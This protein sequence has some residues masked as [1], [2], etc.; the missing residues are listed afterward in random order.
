MCAGSVL[1]SGSILGFAHKASAD[2]VAKALLDSTDPV[3]DA[4]GQCD[5]VEAVTIDIVKET[6]SADA[7][8][9]LASTVDGES[10]LRSSVDVQ[11]QIAILEA[12]VADQSDM[13][14]PVPTNAKTVFSSWDEVPPMPARDASGTAVDTHEISAIDEERS[15]QLASPEP[16]PVVNTASKSSPLVPEASASPHT[17]PRTSA[18]ELDD[19]W[20]RHKEVAAAKS[21]A[22]AEALEVAGLSNLE[23]DLDAETD[24]SESLPDTVDESGEMGVEKALVVEQQEQQE[25]GLRD[26]QGRLEEGEV[27][28]ESPSKSVKVLAKTSAV[29]AAE[30]A[31]K[32]RAAEQEA[33]SADRLAAKARTDAVKARA[34]ESAAAAKA[35]VAAAALSAVDAVK[36]AQNSAVR[37]ESPSPAEAHAEA[38][39]H[40]S[41]VAAAAPA[42]MTV[43]PN[44]M[45]T[46][47][48]DMSIDFDAESDEDEDEEVVLEAAV[49]IGAK[50]REAAQTVAAAKEASART[51]AEEA[52]ARLQA[53]KDAVE[54]A[55]AEMEETRAR[56]EAE[57]AEASLLSAKQREKAHAEIIAELEAEC[58][59]SED[60]EVGEK[61]KAQVAAPLP[62]SPCSVSGDGTGAAEDAA[63]HQ[64]PPEKATAGV[65]V[66][67][68]TP[69]SFYG[70][71]ADDEAESPHADYG[72]TH[73]PYGHELEG[74]S[75]GGS[76]HPSHTIATVDD[77]MSR[78][79]VSRR[80]T[81]TSYPPPTHH[82]VTTHSLAHPLTQP[83]TRIFTTFLQDPSDFVGWLR[84]P[85]SSTK[86]LN[87]GET[88]LAGVGGAHLDLTDFSISHSSPLSGREES[89][90]LTED[91]S[92]ASPTDFSTRSETSGRSG[93]SGFD[94]LMSKIMAGPSPTK[95][96]NS[97]RNGVSAA[98][99]AE[100]YTAVAPSVVEIGVVATGEAA[101]NQA[102]EAQPRAQPRART[103]NVVRN[104]DDSNN[105]SG[106]SDFPFDFSDM[107]ETPTPLGTAFVPDPFPVP[108]EQEDTMQGES[109]VKSEAAAQGIASTAATVISR[110][111]V[112]QLPANNMP[113]ALE[114][115]VPAAANDMNDCVHTISL[116]PSTRQLH[117][118]NLN[119]QA[120]DDGYACAD[121]NALTV[122]AAHAPQVWAPGSFEVGGD[123]VDDG[124]SSEGRSPGG[125]SDGFGA[126]WECEGGPGIHGGE[127]EL[128]LELGMYGHANSHGL[129]HDLDQDDDVRLVEGGREGSSDA[130]S[131]QSYGEEAGE[132][133]YAE[134]QAEHT[135]NAP[136]PLNLAI[137]A[138]PPPPSPR[139]LRRHQHAAWGNGAGSP[140]AAEV[141][142]IPDGR[143]NGSSHADGH[144]SGP[145]S[146]AYAIPD[147]DQVLL[148]SPPSPPPPPPPD[149]EEAGL[150]AQA[151][152]GRFELNEPAL[153][154]G[155][156]DLERERAGSMATMVATHFD[157]PGAGGEGWGGGGAEGGRDGSRAFEAV[158]AQRP[159]RREQRERDRQH[160]SSVARAMGQVLP[161][162]E[163]TG[164]AG[165]E[166]RST[167]DD[168]ATEASSEESANLSL[169][170]A[171][172]GG[173]GGSDHG[174]GLGLGA[175]DGGVTL[176]M[177]N[178][179]SLSVS[180]SIGGEEL[181]VSRSLNMGGGD[182][183]LRM[184]RQGLDRYSQDFSHP[185]PHVERSA[186]EESEEELQELGH[187][188][189]EH[190]HARADTDVSKS[191]RRTSLTAAERYNPTAI[192]ATAVAA[193]ASSA[194][195]S[196]SGGDVTKASR[197]QVG[198]ARAREAASVTP[199]PLSP[200]SMQGSPIMDSDMSATT[201]NDSK[202]SAAAFGPSPPKAKHGPAHAQ[203]QSA[204]G[205]R[206]GGF[207]AASGGNGNGDGGGGEG[208]V[209]HSVSHSV[210]QLRRFEQNPPSVKKRPASSP[211]GGR[212]QVLGQGSRLVSPS[213]PRAQDEQAQFE[214]QQLQRERALL[215]RPS[216]FLI[217]PSTQARARPSPSLG[218]EPP[219][220]HANTGTTP[221]PAQGPALVSP[222]PTAA[223]HGLY[224][225]GAT[226]TAL[227]PNG[228]PAPLS[229]VSG[230]GPGQR[231]S[232]SLILP[233]SPASLSRDASPSLC[234]GQPMA[235]P[236][237]AHGGGSGAGIGQGPDAA[238]LT[239]DVSRRPSPRAL[240]PLGGLGGGV[241]GFPAMSG[242]SPA[243]RLVK[244]GTATAHAMITPSPSEVPRAGAS[245]SARSG[246]RPRSAPRSID[247]HQG[248]PVQPLHGGSNTGGAVLF[249]TPV[250]EARARVRGPAMGETPNSV[251]MLTPSLKQHPSNSV[252]VTPDDQGRAAVDT[253]HGKG[254]GN[255]YYT[256]LM[257]GNP[258]SQ[259]HPRKM[260]LAPVAGD[261]PRGVATVQSSLELAVGERPITSRGRW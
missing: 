84:A 116:P 165:D 17:S 177:R 175:T 10:P 183:P 20:T 151:Y 14:R 59:S 146:Q 200:F 85:P 178:S 206:Q 152:L 15:T 138:P 124:S 106:L 166:A 132:G 6:A 39:E 258:Q 75:Q 133:D 187:D 221:A 42:S 105:G 94:S 203:A 52:S 207:D 164:A 195:R 216:N 156:H 235:P 242:V 61:E 126:L 73:D 131:Y 122:K 30:G 252:A 38:T 77:T 21:K 212:G 5:V 162:G 197:V 127:L 43:M 237:G 233:P 193:A 18:Q 185:G 128:E 119:S 123:Q 199:T 35:R 244:A 102:P 255:A 92:S 81:T 98:A 129:R 245:T 40:E 64:S 180:H 66:V 220:G 256:E 25:D 29:A 226:K 222:S 248:C 223:S 11:E 137:I 4:L 91:D 23:A 196:T 224:Q 44:V 93:R 33:L 250:E 108:T 13:P 154:H 125:Q 1:V 194:R 186:E 168:E 88:S 257:A 204:A 215:S 80:I 54:Q 65:T 144:L 210:S 110:L 111:G 254:H 82:T 19:E 36:Q 230:V 118:H 71:Y 57:M 158:E 28:D 101:K 231:R 259:A 182:T 142:Y 181:S 58:S 147:S 90:N 8:A 87:H 213:P 253:G 112:A 155:A 251:A 246:V 24:E 32:A 209:S 157:G 170:L 225:G 56:L 173:R 227:P 53:V 70:N 145:K 174:L 188:E 249:G 153:I 218:L 100:D 113:P 117:D 3:T 136:A 63:A 217:S 214:Q 171:H 172:G 219:A 97:G 96:D 208:G 139:S 232:Q 201:L 50:E 205:V 241:E 239:L 31:A 192:S 202:A 234:G 148:H 161:G 76:P 120:S 2:L 228:S 107:T 184:R 114:V 34:A 45:S 229:L 109:E 243:P 12:R 134:G 49:S 62:L 238:P 163:A 46:E 41:T 150:E 247:R 191:P 260:V 51:E 198:T 236:S 74:T 67:K 89:G 190:E 261:G 55:K 159:T 167:Y 26:V 141:A 140:L 103:V 48:G 9:S 86:K 240:P 27:S 22:R 95:P 78:M 179:V 104:G 47:G 99:K 83:H 149:D 79:E 189:H 130:Y 72:G 7:Q 160:E 135:G 169:S 121:A 69:V 211:H 16:S 176:S 37:T 68:L 115:E 60:E 143:S